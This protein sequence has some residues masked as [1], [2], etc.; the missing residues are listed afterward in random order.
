MSTPSPVPEKQ[1]PAAAADSDRPGAAS[2]PAVPTSAPAARSDSLL[3]R[4]RWWLW[5]LAAVVIVGGAAWGYPWLTRSLNTVSTDDAYVNGHV[6]FVAP[7]VA[8]QVARVL[9]EDNNVV[10]KGDLLVEL[11]P[12][13]Y[14]VQ[15]NIA[16]A[17][18]EAARADLIA[19]Q[20]AVRGSEGLARSL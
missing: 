17:A 5:L 2:R 12:E 9:V 15:V 4:R 7:R 19:T 11:D 14:Q 10:R 16:Q 20:S 6:T 3:R 18:F 8:G 1:S 13:P